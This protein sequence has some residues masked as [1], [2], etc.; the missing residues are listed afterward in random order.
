MRIEIL[1]RIWI[2][3]KI[4]K[5]N[6]IKYIVHIIEKINNIYTISDFIRRQ[7]IYVKYLEDMTKFLYYHTIVKQKSILLVDPYVHERHDA[8]MICIAFM[9]FY[10]KV[11]WTN[12][13]KAIKEKTIPFTLNSFSA[14]TLNLFHPT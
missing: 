12:V 14:G 8:Y 7:H 5:K 2:A 9:T 4:P 1:P 11:H 6:K 3:D 10:G 13:Y